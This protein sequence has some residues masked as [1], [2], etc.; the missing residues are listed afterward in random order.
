MFGVNTYFGPDLGAI[1]WFSAVR[2]NWGKAYEY[3]FL[4]FIHNPYMFAICCAPIYALV[5]REFSKI[6]IAKK[7]DSKRAKIIKRKEFGLKYYQC[8]LLIIAG[9][10]SHFFF[11]Y[12]FDANGMGTTFRWVIETGSWIDPQFDIW[13]I[14]IIPICATLLIGYSAINNQRNQRSYSK[15]LIHSFILLIS[16]SIIYLI[17]LGIRLSLGLDAVGEE[18]DFG[19]IIFS[20]IFIFIPLALCLFSME[21]LEEFYESSRAH[22]SH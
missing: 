12:I 6:G 4:T 10:F 22:N 20:T 18:A 7:E 2:Y 11:D 3:L 13:V 9:G 8:L 21:P 17:Y 15:K 1:L 5:W 19:V 16:V 14:A